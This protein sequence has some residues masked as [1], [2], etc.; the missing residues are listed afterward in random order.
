M[1]SKLLLLGALLRVTD[2]SYY[3]K[4][5]NHLKQYEDFALRNGMEHPG[6]AHSYEAKLEYPAPQFDHPIDHPPNTIAPQDPPLAIMDNS[7]WTSAVNASMLI[8]PACWQSRFNWSLSLVY[9]ASKSVFRSGF[10][11]VQVVTGSSGY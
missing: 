7:L 8:P 5:P 6:F 1:L 9:T 2:A 11:P 3:A 10:N 4:D